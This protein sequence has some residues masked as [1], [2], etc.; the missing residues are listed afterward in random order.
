MKT[1]SFLRTLL[2]LTLILFFSACTN[3]DSPP[4]PTPTDPRQEEPVISESACTTDADCVP[5]P[6]CHPQRCI[7]AEFTDNYKQP[8]FCTEQFDF[9]AAY[10]AE[11]CGCQQGSCV[12]LNADRTGGPDTPPPHGDVSGVNNT[13]LPLTVSAGFTLDVFTDEVSGAR[14]IVGPDGRGNLW[15]SRTKEGRV[16]L[17]EPGEDGQ[18]RH[19]SDIFRDL[20]SPHGLALDPQNNMMLYVAESDRVFRIPLYTD[21]DPEELVTLPDGGRHFTRTLHFGPDDKLYVSI[22][23]SCD[24]CEE[25]DE[26]RA[27]VYR[28]DKDGSNFEPYATGLRNAVFLATNPI[29]GDIWTTEMGR[30][31][32]GDNL[33]PDEINILEE[34]GDYGWPVCYG[35]QVYDSVFDA[36]PNASSPC[37]ETV[38]SSIDIPAHSAPLGL[39]FVPEEGWPEGYWLDLLVAYHGSWNRTEPRAPAVMHYILNDTGDLLHTEPLIEGFLSE[40]GEK[41]GR[42]VDI[43]TMPGG[44]AYITDD[45]NGAVYRLTSNGAAGEGASGEETS[46]SPR[47]SDNDE[48][49]SGDTPEETSET[50]NGNNGGEDDANGNATE[51]SA[52]EEDKN[53]EEAGGEVEG[54]VEGR[55]EG[56]VEIGNDVEVDI[57]GEGTISTEKE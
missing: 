32:L 33:P 41:L 36:Q 19:V 9:S 12:N 7:N 57:Q 40:D 15:L 39:A 22:G 34:S 56:E 3:E 37:D 51:D 47:A 10:S 13:D 5:V 24:V 45:Q 55:V 30:D 35:K 53:T 17:L 31:Q 44:I 8:E 52:G 42:P 18:V 23:S 46:S 26:R 43:L 1:F 25:E 21:A 49:P 27:A 20:N 28:M 38:P 54:E 14:V 29:T 16:S 2:V 6:S 48:S 50:S 4:P 11:D